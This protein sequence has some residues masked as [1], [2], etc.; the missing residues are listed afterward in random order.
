MSNPRI[1]A[2]EITGQHEADA[3]SI[4]SLFQ[5]Y[6]A[7]KTEIGKVRATDPR[8]QA[9]T[10]LRYVKMDAD[11]KTQLIEAIYQDL[12]SFPNFRL[13]DVAVHTAVYVKELGT[14]AYRDIIPGGDKLSEDEARMKIIGEVADR[15]IYLKAAEENDRPDLS[16]INPP[17]GQALN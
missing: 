1:V 7:E 13:M 11:E 5:L 16:R 6:E 3:K 10:E 9:L 17:E 8:Y 2:I 14:L 12:T 4:E 15:A